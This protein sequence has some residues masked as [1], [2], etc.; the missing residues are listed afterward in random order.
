MRGKYTEMDS[1]L[2]QFQNPPV[3]NRSTF[4]TGNGYK[5]EEYFNIF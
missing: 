5:L 3:L 1:Y 2:T 4:P